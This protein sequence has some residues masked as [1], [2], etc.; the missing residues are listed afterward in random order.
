MWKLNMFYFPEKIPFPSGFRKES[1]EKIMDYP[2]RYLKIGR[3][4]NKVL[5]LLLLEGKLY[6]CG[7]INCK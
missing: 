6:F 3:E 1:Q 4:I 2:Y 5:P 7:V